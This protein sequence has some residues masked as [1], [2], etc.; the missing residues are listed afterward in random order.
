[1]RG[2]IYRTIIT[3]IIFIQNIFAEVRMYGT[4]VELIRKIVSIEI[5]RLIT[6]MI[7]GSRI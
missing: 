3:E 4:V 6:L 5:N 7:V 2:E 1:M